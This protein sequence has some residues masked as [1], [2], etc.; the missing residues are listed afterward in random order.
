VQTSPPITL[1]R[2]DAQHLLDRIDPAQ[3][4]QDVTVLLGG[5]ISA[6]FEVRCSDGQSVV[7]KIYSDSF[8]WKMAKEVL[9]Y[10]LLQAHGVDAPVARILLADDSK[11]VLPYTILVL[12]KLEGELVSGLDSLADHTL[13]DIYRQ[14]GELLRTLHQVTFDEFGYVGT[15]G[16]ETSHPT[17]LAY[18]QVQFARKRREF[19]ELGGDPELSRRL[20][21]HVA[22]REQ[23]FAGC[24]RAVLCHNDCHEGNVLVTPEGDG[25]RVS[26]LV[27]FENVVAGDPLLDLAK[28]YYYSRRGDEV[29]DALVAG[30]GDRRDGW[31]A[32]LDLYMLYHVVELWAWFARLGDRERLAKVTDDLRRL[33]A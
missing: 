4:V 1:A 3:S 15:Q 28:S 33:T 9:V 32:A 27:D 7:F 6:V 29:L 16:I 12:T 11:S 24:H 17:N 21:L 25:W 5:E 20:R 14:M 23:L 8:H 18:M 22:E 19:D 31:R 2:T 10:G 30:Y 26:G 13:A